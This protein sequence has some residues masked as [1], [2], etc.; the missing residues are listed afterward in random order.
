MTLTFTG[1]DI[2]PPPVVHLDRVR[3]E[4]GDREGAFIH[5]GGCSTDHEPFSDTISTVNV[6]FNPQI[7]ILNGLD[8]VTEQRVLRHEEQHHRDFMEIA[9]RLHQRLDRAVRQNQDPQLNDRWAWF[10]YDLKTRANRYHQ[11]TGEG[12]VVPVSEP[13]CPRPG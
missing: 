13:D 7:Q 4:Y 3:A 2:N 5:G 11:Q 12:V 8:V 6:W 10:L 9:Q 1:H